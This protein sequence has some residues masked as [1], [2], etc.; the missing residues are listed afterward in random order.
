[1]TAMSL[2]IKSEL[3][4]L[5][6][7]HL[8][9]RPD[10]FSRAP[11]CPACRMEGIFALQH[12]LFECKDTMIQRASLQYRRQA[13]EKIIEDAVHVYPNKWDRA[14]LTEVDSRQDCFD[15]GL[16]ESVLFRE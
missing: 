9:H 13:E 2:R 5:T 1:M 6:M 14:I 8:V 16:A 7:Q 15:A 11:L 4:T 10:I 3:G 12:L